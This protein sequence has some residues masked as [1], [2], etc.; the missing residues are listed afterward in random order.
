M[1]LRASFRTPL[2]LVM[3]FCVSLILLSF[4]PLAHSQDATG[5]PPFGTFNR[6]QIDTI[7]VGNLNVHF[8]FPLFTKQG[9]GLNYT[10]NIVHDNMVSVGPQPP[11]GYPS[12]TFTNLDWWSPL[13]P[14]GGGLHWSTT[15][16]T[17]YM[18]AND[19]HHPTEIYNN[20]YF[21]DS[22][23]TSHSFAPAQMDSAG[24]NASV[25]GQSIDGW[26]LTTS[27]FTGQ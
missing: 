10:A 25:N 21:I 26:T 5:L 20:F 27:T 23:G 24:C 17:C 14:L 6:D 8:Q 2:R 11:Q 18:S 16:S 1:P 19:P 4:I 15:D 22:N 12:W 7:N 9:R 3:S 13:T